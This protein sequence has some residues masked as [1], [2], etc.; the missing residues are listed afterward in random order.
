MAE[1]TR[2]RPREEVVVVLSSDESEPEPSFDV[3]Q[4]RTKGSS[5]SPI[6]LC[7]SQ[8]AE[9]ASVDDGLGESQSS[10]VF[11]EERKNGVLCVD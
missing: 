7:E 8:L 3:D 2:K 5:A 11:L 10:V 9:N 6:S 1:A 4:L